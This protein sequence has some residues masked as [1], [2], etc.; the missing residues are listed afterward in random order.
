MGCGKTSLTAPVRLRHGG[1]GP[2]APVSLMKEGAVLRAGGEGAFDIRRHQGRLPHAGVAAKAARPS[3]LSA[4]Q[5][6]DAPLS[7]RAIQAVPGAPRRS[8]PTAVGMVHL[9][10]GAL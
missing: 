5:E 6:R 2:L 10:R 9:P 3:D 4:P 8:A 1:G 7:P